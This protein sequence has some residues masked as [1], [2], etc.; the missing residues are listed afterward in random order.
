MNEKVTFKSAPT[1]GVSACL[2]GE[3]VRWD[4]S[5]KPNF[6]VFDIL[7]NHINLI[8]VCPE[9]E[10]G[11]GIPREAVRLE[12]S[13]N[14]P[15]MT[16]VKTGTD[17]TAKMTDYTNKRIKKLYR[18]S[19]CGFIFKG[20]SP[21]CGIEQINVFHLK[22][23]LLEKGSGMFAGKIIEKFPL[24]PIID[25]KTLINP[26]YRNDFIVRIFAYY[27]LQELFKDHRQTN[28]TEHF[29]ESSRYF[30]K[31]FS[32][33]HYKDLRRLVESSKDY[34]ALDFQIKY[35]RLFM[36][37]LKLKST[38]KKNIIV[39]HSII[40]QLKN[41]ISSNEEKMIL[42]LVDEYQK[43]LISLSV[44]LAPIRQ[45]IQIYNIE[46]LGAQYYIFPHPKELKLRFH[47]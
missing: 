29:T 8:P 31:S 40:G 11:M 47:V 1:I 3:K 45:F 9:A 25:D 14:S 32:P 26:I 20:K 5:S 10:T 33:R 35:C 43:G 39:L 2:A 41:W 37:T 13:L 44:P 34:P 16:A 42:G 18:M 6:Y 23:T 17:W 24:L 15:R 19:L 27:R 21:S 22:N 4:G 7:A 46:K 28:A 12:G 36:E 38:V 30:L